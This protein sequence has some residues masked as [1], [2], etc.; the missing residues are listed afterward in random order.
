M[1]PEHDTTG[2]GWNPAAMGA[3]AGIE[4]QLWANRRLLRTFVVR[5]LRARYAGSSLG[6]FWSVI[7]PVVVLG[8]YIVVFSTL[9]RGGRFE[10]QGHPVSY[11][12]FLCPALLAWNWF[13]EAMM[14]GASA[15][16]GN[17][18]LIKKVVFP[19]GI[20]PSVP[21]LA[22]LVPFVVA[23]AVFLVFAAFVGAFH[24]RSLPWLGVALLIQAA[25][26]VGPAY[27]LASV[28]VFARD[29]AQLLVALLQFLF[30]GTPIVYTE[31]IV[32][33]AFPW[34]QAWYSINPMAHL[35]TVYRNAVI[36][37]EGP[38]AASAAYLLL[39]AAALYACGRV[40]FTRTRRLFPDEV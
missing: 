33:R 5:E 23:F 14:G 6:V 4:S 16:V 26:M 19:S 38:P 35:V 32:V 25:L 29:T 27:L 2:A 24:W 15:I 34:A 9:V 17:G 11:A 12:V 18:G 36:L 21:L 13:N 37:R 20:L 39:L 31:E 30:W 1:T 22:G 7:H 28:Q 8:L 40:V 10:V 3:R